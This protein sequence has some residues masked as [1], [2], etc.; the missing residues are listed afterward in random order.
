MALEPGS[1]HGTPDVQVL[2]ET[3]RE[4]SRMSNVRSMTCSGL[5]LYGS[6]LAVDLARLLSVRAGKE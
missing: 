6:S 5:T 2:L 4:L 3:M 1:D